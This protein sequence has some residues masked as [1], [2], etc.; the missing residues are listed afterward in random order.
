[1]ENNKY[2]LIDKVMKTAVRISNEQNDDTVYILDVSN[3]SLWEYYLC[4][5]YIIFIY[6]FYSCFMGI[7]KLGII[8]GFI[9]GLLIFP[10]EMYYYSQMSFKFKCPIAVDFYEEKTEKA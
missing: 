6:S 8:K 2:I 4:A 5:L 10:L 7:K 3:S 9:F 1:M